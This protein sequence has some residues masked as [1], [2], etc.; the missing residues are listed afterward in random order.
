MLFRKRIIAIAAAGLVLGGGAVAG[1][2]VIGPDSDGGPHV[3]NP[4]NVV[5]YDCGAVVDNLVKTQNQ[6]VETSVPA[7]PGVAVPGAQ[8]QIAVPPNQQRC[9]KLLF[10]AE[11]SC[12]GYAGDDFCYVRALVDG[13][14]MDPDGQQFQALDSEDATA[15]AHAYEWIGHVGPGVHNI[16]ILRRVG[17]PNTVFRLDDYTSD[18][19]VLQL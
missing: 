14:P 4:P 16:T 19:E 9:L 3:D 18:L 6:P 12:T 10:T 11:S 5:S 13:Q 15:S 17:N 8:F 1:A 2:Q 7:L